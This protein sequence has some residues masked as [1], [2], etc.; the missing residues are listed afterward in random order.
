MIWR[1]RRCKA[2]GSKIDFT[3]D[4][5]YVVEHREGT[6][7]SV[8][9]TYFDAFDCPKCGTQ[10]IVGVREMKASSEDNE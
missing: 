4:G 10:C 5:H 9:V 6:A 7:L 3:K 8:I 1:R 2:C